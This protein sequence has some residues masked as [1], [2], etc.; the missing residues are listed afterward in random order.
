MTG[1]D[2]QVALLATQTN[3]GKV[4]VIAKGNTLTVDIGGVREG[5]DPSVRITL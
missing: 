3:T 2:K 4:M 5:E 1:I